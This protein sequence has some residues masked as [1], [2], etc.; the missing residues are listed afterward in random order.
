MTVPPRTYP[1]QEQE[2]YTDPDSFGFARSLLYSGRFT[3][4]WDVKVRSTIDSLAEE[5]GLKPL[6]LLPDEIMVED[7][8]P[9]YEVYCASEAEEKLHALG[10]PQLHNA[11]RL[12]C[13][14]VG[15][16][17]ACG[18]LALTSLM[19]QIPRYGVP[20]GSELVVFT[21]STRNIV[22]EVFDIHIPLGQTLT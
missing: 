9:F 17:Q 16:D 12:I 20:Q 19:N 1:R 14:D 6:V 11:P 18:Y 22:E 3:D 7:Y 13:I 2:H 8:S 15:L 21:D 5:S 10:D 4:S